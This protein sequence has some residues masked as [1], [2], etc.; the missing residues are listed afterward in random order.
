MATTVVVNFIAAE[1]KEK[2]LAESLTEIV[3]IIKGYHTCHN[4]TLFISEQA[5]GKMMIIEEWES[6]DEHQKFYAELKENGSFDQVAKLFTD[7][8]FNYFE[9]EDEKI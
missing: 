4:A 7:F 5:P 8:S 3:E 9:K 1:G 2:L 6:S